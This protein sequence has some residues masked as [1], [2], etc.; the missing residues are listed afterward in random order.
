MVFLWLRLLRAGVNCISHELLVVVL[1]YVSGA[2][3]GIGC[4][5]P[6][7]PGKKKELPGLWDQRANHIRAVEG[8]KQDQA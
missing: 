8:C 6:F 4:M 5:T 2:S 3:F 1:S 7:L